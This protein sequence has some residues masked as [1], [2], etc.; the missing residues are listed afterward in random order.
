MLIIKGFPGTG[1]TIRLLHYAKKLS[2]ENKKVLFLN[3]NNE[4]ALKVAGFHA[5][6]LPIRFLSYSNGQLDPFA[7]EQI[8]QQQNEQDGVDI[9][10]IDSIGLMKVRFRKESILFN[11]NQNIIALKNIESKMNVHIIVTMCVSETIEKYPRILL[12][13]EKV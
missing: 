13:E 3:L 4:N 12:M 1:K 6:D 2:S 5:L 9:I 8:I 11:S 7:I 10:C